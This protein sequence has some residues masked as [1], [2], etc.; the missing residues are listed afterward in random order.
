MMRR[1][2]I[3]WSIA[4][5]L[6]VVACSRPPAADDHPRGGSAPAEVAAAVADGVLAEVVGADGAAIRVEQAGGRRLLTIAGTVH[7]SVAW[8]AAG[9]DPAVIDPLVA[10]L[11]QVRPAA[12]TAL[13]IGLGSGDTAGDLARA[14]VAVTAVEIDP[15][16][17]AVARRWFGYQ[18]DA[19]VGDGRAFLEAN[20]GRWDLVI[21][22]AFAGTTA[23]SRL[24]D[25][26]G[27]RLLR[28]RTAKDGVTAVRLHGAPSDPIVASLRRGLG[29]GAR[30]PTFVHVYGSGVGAEPQNLYLA[31]STA[32]LNEIGLDGAALWP[33]PDDPAALQ[34]IASGAGGEPAATR[35]VTLVGYAHRLGGGELALDL[36]HAEMGAVRYLLTGDGARGVTVPDGGFPTAGDIASD[37]DTAA[38]L[39]PLLGGGGA[40]R[41]DLRFSPVVAAVSGRARLIAVVHP[42]AA[43]KVPHPAAAAVDDR[44]PYG[45]ALYELAVSRVHWTMDRAAWSA[46]APALDGH[47]ASAGAAAARGD[48]AA[49]ATEVAA[50][51]DTL[52][53]RLG[54]HS[55]LVPAIATARAL[56]TAMPGEADRARARGTDFARA[57]ACDRLRHGHG[58][59][60]PAPVAAGLYR[61]AVQGYERAAAGKDPTA[62]DAYDAAARL[63]ALL[64]DAPDAKAA[65]R[66]RRELARR[67]KLGQPMRFPP[68]L[69]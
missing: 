41:S 27:T 33:I 49:A 62:A 15:Q 58:S 32:P 37:G 28:E 2:T 23:P 26:A 61:C 9:P 25:A 48:L 46:I 13:V 64:D 6:V 38:T 18:G 4:P 59:A 68:G 54:A 11:R 36:P 65:E 21:M 67:F 22:D 8:T 39:R 31:A 1:M 42:D 30:G 14:G 29:A 57:A 24:V 45:G 43:S 51:A 3:R 66:R 47:A 53:G 20:P 44:I 69:F 50:W 10:L 34:S 63:L 55:E 5:L 56:A 19:V 35:E 16:V 40:K 12:R 60:A 7:A 52:A 17:I